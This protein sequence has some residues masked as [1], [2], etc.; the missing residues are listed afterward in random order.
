MH[1]LAAELPED[2]WPEFEGPRT[3]VLPRPSRAIARELAAGLVADDGEDHE[4]AVARFMDNFEACIPT[5]A[6]RLRI[7]VR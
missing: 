4:R 2:V 5:C 6:S 7:T 1:N 3:S